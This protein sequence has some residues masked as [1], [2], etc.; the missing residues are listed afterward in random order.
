MVVAQTRIERDTVFIPGSITPERIAN[1][2][3]AI[4]LLSLTRRLLR[5]R[6]SGGEFGDNGILCFPCATRPSVRAWKWL[7]GEIGDA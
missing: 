7:Y 3:S 2:I 6:S 4:A 1:R 5:K